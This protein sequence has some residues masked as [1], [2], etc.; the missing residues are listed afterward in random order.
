MFYFAA[1]LPCVKFTIFARFIHLVAC[2]AGMILHKPPNIIV[3]WILIQF[4]SIQPQTVWFFV[5]NYYAAKSLWKESGITETHSF[6]PPFQQICSALCGHHRFMKYYDEILYSHN[7]C[8]YYDEL[9]PGWTSGSNGECR[10][11]NNLLLG[12]DRS[13]ECTCDHVAIA[14]AILIDVNRS[15]STVGYPIW[16]HVSCFVK[17]VSWSWTWSLQVINCCL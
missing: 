4:H 17:M 8:V 1:S 9:L 13:V 2:W 6:M 10:I 14:Y 12:I 7:R 11:V 15:P 3:Q 16:F 5:W